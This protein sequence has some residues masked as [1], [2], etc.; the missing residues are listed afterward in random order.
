MK[1]LFVLLVLFVWGCKQPV[2]PCADVTCLNGGACAEGT[3]LCVDDFFGT[4]CE[5]EPC[6][7]INCLNGGTCAS[8]ACE[9]PLGY[10]GNRCQFIGRNF[11]LGTYNCS[12]ICTPSTARV[13]TVATVASNQNYITISGIKGYS[14]TVQL[15]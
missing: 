4:L 7:T 3:C 5:Q 13:Y 10:F 1:N 14:Q 8:G 6:D 15:Q 9:C 2:D 12:E 11:V